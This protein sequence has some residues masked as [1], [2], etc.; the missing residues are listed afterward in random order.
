MLILSRV[1]DIQLNETII[2]QIYLKSTHSDEKNVLEL[3]E[4]GDFCQWTIDMPF[5]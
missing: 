1:D 2:F 5:E 3:Q 4:F